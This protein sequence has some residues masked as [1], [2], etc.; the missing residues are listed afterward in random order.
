MRKTTNPALILAML[1]AAAVASS[2]LVAPARVVGE[3]FQDDEFP[4]MAGEARRQYESWIDDWMR[5]PVEVLFTIEEREI[6]DTLEDTQQRRDFIQWF[7]DRRDPDGRQIGN[8]FQEAFYE[9]VAESN[10]KYRGIPKGWKSDRGRVHLL[11]GK[12]GYVGR[13]TQAQIFGIAGA[14]E[15]EVWSYSNFGSNLAFQGVSGEFLIYF[16]ETRI[17]RFEI[18]DF[19]WGAGV[20]DRNIRT[21][22]DWTIEGNIIDPMMEFE[23]GA[24]SGA[25]VREITEGTL[26]MLIPLEAWAD[27]GG[28]GAIS[29]PVQVSIGDLLFQPDGDQFV[30]TLEAGLVARSSV[31]PGAAQASEAW[32]VR[33]GEEELLTVGNGSFIT[34]VTV[35]AEPGA[36]E[37]ELTVAHPLAA[38]DG[39]WSGQVDVIAD[40]SI[41]IVVG[42]TALS[43]DPA[44]AST[45]GVL[46]SDDSTFDSGG[47]LVV[48]AWISGVEPDPAALSL[49]LE[50]SDGSTLVLTIEEARWLG[51]VAGPLLVRA[52]IPDLDTGSY[53]LRV[54]FGAGLEAATTL[55]QV[56]R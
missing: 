30:A 35:A 20:W 7:W 55:V 52:R 48:G 6:W 44:D 37:V 5:G 12:P 34:P 51:G 56:A 1:A 13:Q 18:F 41:A 36:Y 21:A 19:Q 16:I 49:Q 38:T 28:G 17:G 32:E 26:P 9:S 24:S 22:F 50:T 8:K 4:T 2:L 27:P 25:Y 33:L 11:F 23:T 42:Q 10:L 3:P 29:V 31:G 15:F 45:V 53:R 54:D 47:P 43:L 40:P 39:E 14:S 46:M